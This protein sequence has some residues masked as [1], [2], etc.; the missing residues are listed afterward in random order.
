M[1]PTK[2]LRVLLI[3]DNEEDFAAI[4]SLLAESAPE[5]STLDWQRSHESGLA[6]LRDPGYDACLLDCTPAGRT[7]LDLLSEAV[8]KDIRAAMILLT[9]DEGTGSGL[10]GFAADYL[11]KAELSAKALRR[12]IWY[13]V[14]RKRVEMELAR[15]GERQ[16]ELLKRRE[17]ELRD[18]KRNS[19]LKTVLDSLPHPFY[20]VD[21]R[22]YGILLANNSALPEELPRN[23]KCHSMFHGSDQPCSG[24]EHSCPLLEICKTRKPMIAKHIHHDSAGRTRHVEVHGYPILDETG[25]CPRSSSTARYIRQE[26]DRG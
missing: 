13:A 23:V 17:E 20:V 5:G 16:A 8:S 14:Q 7:G 15:C 18:I 12:S 3:G 4:R 11:V 25:E 21:A 19:F 9:P 26:R 24:A 2:K 6:A 10:E 22:D 1:D